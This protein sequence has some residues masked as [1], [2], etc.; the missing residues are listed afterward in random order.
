MTHKNWF[1]NL[2]LLNND[3]S[4]LCFPTFKLALMQK[5][6]K[7]YFCP[8]FHAFFST[9]QS[10]Q[11]LRKVHGRCEKYFCLHLPSM[12][13]SPHESQCK[14]WKKLTR[15][16]SVRFTL[17]H[18][19]FLDL[20]ILYSRFL[21]IIRYTDCRFPNFLVIRELM[22]Q[23]AYNVFY[24]SFSWFMGNFSWTGDWTIQLVSSHCPLISQDYPQANLSKL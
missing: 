6:F 19:S 8:P 18:I 9:R 13:S 21:W 23:L 11:V 17:S 12:Q 3:R 16:W 20:D 4:S 22:R 2:G 1:S 5:A 15:L 7:K 10:L 24:T 14:C